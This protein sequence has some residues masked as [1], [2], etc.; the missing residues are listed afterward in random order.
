ML[1]SHFRSRRLVTPPPL[2]ILNCLADMISESLVIGSWVFFCHLRFSERFGRQEC[3]VVKSSEK[4]SLSSLGKSTSSINL[5]PPYK[6]YS[7][8]T[9]LCN[10]TPGSNTFRDKTEQDH[11]DSSEWDCLSLSL[12]NTYIKI[13]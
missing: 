1:T 8:A 9:F 2:L 5:N 11:V 7:V 3:Q 10:R 13:M 12:K 6:L 4:Q